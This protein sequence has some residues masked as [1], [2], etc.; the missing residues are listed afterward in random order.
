LIIKH[1]FKSGVRLVINSQPY[2]RSAAMGIYVGNGSRNEKKS[3]G[4]I[5]HFIEH[6]MFKGTEKRS[7]ADIAEEMDIMGGQLNAYTTKEY[8][9][10]YARVLN[11]NLSRAADILCDMY[12]NSAFKSDEIEREASVI[13]EE[14]NMYDDTPDELVVDEL[15]SGIWKNDNPLG[16]PIL[17]TV[18]SV[19]SFKRE[20]FTAYL[21]GHYRPDNTVVAV[22]GNVDTDSVISLLEKY[23][24]T[25]W[26]TD[27]SAIPIQPA[28]YQTCTRHKHK[29]IEQAHICLT[30]EGIPIGD[31]HIYDMN[32]LNTVLGGSMSSRLYQCI[33]EKYALAYAIYS[34][35]SCYR[36]TGIFTVYAAVNPDREKHTTELILSEIKNIFADKLTVEDVEKAKMQIKSNYLLGLDNTVNLI[37][38]CGRNMLLRNA[39]I[40]SADV[41]SRID[42]V[43]L[44]SIYELADKIFREDKLSISVVSR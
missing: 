7:A 14:I 5:S 26:E 3:Q 15:Q 2:G 4:G 35:M 29:D 43:T 6:M 8:T 38:A 27:N 11:D 25:A 44:E 20:D 34:Y 32:V 1:T 31:K 12:F 17:G 28:E 18:E 10:Y 16:R 19:Y 13:A 30:Y 22:A 37:E 36:D 40:E 23:F 9:C 42:A 33:R 24:G 41:E 21:R 39:I